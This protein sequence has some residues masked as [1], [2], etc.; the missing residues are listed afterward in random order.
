MSSPKPEFHLQHIH[1]GGATSDLE[2]YSAA[3]LPAETS[4]ER[5]RFIGAGLSASA[6]LAAILASSKEAQAA[7]SIGGPK[8]RPNTIFAHAKSVR[9]LAV[10][11]DGQWLVS[12]SEDETLKIWSLPSGKHQATMTGHRD[13]VNSV[14]ISPDDK[15]I[16]SASDDNT[17]RMWSLPAGANQRTLTGHSGN[18]YVVAFTPTGDKLASMGTG[19]ELKLWSMPSGV[20]VESFQGLSRAVEA[21][22]R[23]NVPPALRDILAEPRTHVTAFAIANEAKRLAYAAGS[24]GTKIHVWKLPDGEALPPFSRHSGRIFALAISVDGQL[25]ASSATDKTIKITNLVDASVVRS[26]SVTTWP[27]AL[28]FTGD[29]RSVISGHSDGSI[30]IW[31]VATGKPRGYCFDERTS[32]TDGASID[33]Y[34]RGVGRTITY[35]MPCGS[36]IP[37]GATCICNCVPGRGIAPIVRTT[38]PDTRLSIPAPRPLAFCNPV[39]APPNPYSR[40]TCVPV[41]TCIPVFR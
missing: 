1:D 5:R 36:P 6:V 41:C 7:T 33:A 15:L 19:T 14:A 4:L 16:A 18:V 34:E 21:L 23:W 20:A 31:D 3:D 17:V 32:W 30:I 22:N 27:N 13:P 29:G 10:S 40:C 26:I 9:S 37:R 8:T 24:S 11:S 35:T 2:I 39:Y 28:A 38:I 25:L 12:G